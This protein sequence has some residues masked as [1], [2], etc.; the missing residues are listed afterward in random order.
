MKE[1]EQA[2]EKMT[3]LKGKK[4][5]SVNKIA[6]VCDAGMGSSAMGASSLRKKIQKAGFGRTAAF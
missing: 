5:E 4:A 6:F 2:K 3:E 1:L